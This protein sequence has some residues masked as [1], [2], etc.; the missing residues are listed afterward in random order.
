MLQKIS[1][2]TQELKYTDVELCS[3]CLY[4]EITSWMNEKW[5]ELH[6]EARKQIIDELKSVK[7][8]N[9]KC[10]VCD[11]TLV[12]DRTTEKILKILEE[13]KISDKLKK[14]FENYFLKKEF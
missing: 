11:N 14:E 13:N 9:G 6:E 12:S 5:K 2:P 8:R 7:L 1:L 10:I 4:H 3:R